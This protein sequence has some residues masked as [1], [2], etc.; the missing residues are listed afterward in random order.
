[1]ITA[2]YNVWDDYE[3]LKHSIKHVR[4]LVDEIIVV[5]SERSNYGEYSPP[6]ASALK[7]VHAYNVTPFGG[8]VREKETQKRNFGL[9]KAREFGAD[10]FL[11]M[12]ADEFYEPEPFKH[13]FERLKKSNAAGMVCRVKCYFGS[14]RL[15][16]G[17][18]TTLVPFIHK[19]TPSLRFEFNRNYPFAWTD[20]D[21]KPFTSKKRIRIDPTRSMNIDNGVTW[22]E[23]TMHHLS[24]VRKDPQKKI[25]NSTA[26]SNLERSTVIRDLA[27]A[28]PGYFC[29]FY[30]KTLEETPNI[31]GLPDAANL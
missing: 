22:S 15:T 26:R 8:D 1:M 17:F 27:N 11:M 9:E 28:K 10:Y 13:E 31:F 24:W 7:G 20:E 3:L 6:D 16:I 12:D 19:V 5:Y 14:P 4:P 2:I 18:D 29:E 30:G 23:I 25:R 21:K